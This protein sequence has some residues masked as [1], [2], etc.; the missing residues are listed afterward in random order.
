MR[1]RPFVD[2]PGTI[3]G[4]GNRTVVTFRGVNDR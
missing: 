2:L 4:D 3:M 1:L